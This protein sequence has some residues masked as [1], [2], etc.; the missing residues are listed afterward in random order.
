MP[1][2]PRLTATPEVE[3]EYR[4][5]LGR[6][7]EIWDGVRAGKL[8]PSPE[9]DAEWN[10][11]GEQAGRLAERFGIDSRSSNRIMSGRPR[12]ARTPEAIRTTFRLIKGG[13]E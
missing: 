10:R 1:N 9:L 2:V 5:L 12:G 7:R 4:R 3:A 8:E 11:V 6:W 13:K